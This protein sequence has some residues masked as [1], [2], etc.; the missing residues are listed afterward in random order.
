V[1]DIIVDIAKKNNVHTIGNDLYKDGN[2]FS[3]GGGKTKYVNYAFGSKLHLALQQL[4][5]NNW[6]LDGKI[7]LNQK[8][9]SPYTV[10]NI[11]ELRQSLGMEKFSEITAFHSYYEW[12]NFHSI[13]LQ[14]NLNKEK[15][16]W[17]RV[18]IREILLEKYPTIQPW[19]WVDRNLLLTEITA[20]SRIR[21]DMQLINR[22]EPDNIPAF[23]THSVYGKVMNFLDIR[24]SPLII[25]SDGAHAHGK[26]AAKTASSFAICCLDIRSSENL[27][28]A[29]WIHR[30][31]IPILARTCQLPHQIGSTQADIAHGEG[32]A[33]LMQ[34]MCFEAN[35]PRI[36][37]SDSKAIREQF[38]NIR[39]DNTNE[40]DRN[41]VRKAAGG[42]SKYLVSIV[43][44][45]INT[46]MNCKPDT[47]NSD[48]SGTSQMRAK[49]QQRTDHFL[50]IAKSWITEDHELNGENSTSKG[51]DQ[52]YFDDHR[53]R[54]IL[55]VDSHQLDKFGRRIK[56]SPRY[57]SLVPNIALLSANHHADVGAEIGTTLAS[58]FDNTDAPKVITK[59]KTP[60]SS[61]TFSLMCE[62]ETVDRHI[63]EDINRRFQT[64]RIKRLKTKQTQGFLWRIFP[65]VTI[66]WATLNLHKGFF[67][68]LLGMSNSHSRCIYKSTTYRAGALQQHL[69]TVDDA[70]TRKSIAESSIKDQNRYIL[71]CAWCTTSNSGVHKGNRRHVIL[72]CSNLKISKFRRRMMNLIGQHISTFFE[73]LEKIT[74][75]YAT[76]SFIKEIEKVFLK[77]QNDQM[78]CLKKLSTARNILYIDIQSCLI[79][80]QKESITAARESNAIEFFLNLF[81]VQPER[82]AIEPTDEE[83]GVLDAI[84]MGLMPSTVAKLIQKHIKICSMRLNLDERSSWRIQMEHSW[85]TIENLNMGRVIGIHRIMS[86]VGSDLEQEFIS[87]FHLQDLEKETRKRKM[88]RKHATAAGKA[89]AQGINAKRQKKLTK[90]Q[91]S[92][93]T[94]CNGITCGIEKIRWCS[95]SKLQPNMIRVNRKQCLRC[96]LFT[97]AM[98]TTVNMLIDLQSTSESQQSKLIQ[99]LR[100]MGNKK[101]IN[102]SSLMNMLQG[103]IPKNKQFERAQYISKYRPTEKWKK[104]CKLLIELASR[105]K[106][107]INKG[108]CAKQ[109]LQT[110]ITDMEQTLHVKNNELKTDALFLRKCMEQFQAEIQSPKT[111]SK[112][113]SP[114]SKLKKKAA[115]GKH[116][117]Q[118]CTHQPIE[119][120][121]MV[122]SNDSVIIIDNS[123]NSTN[124]EE[125]TTSS[126]HHQTQEEREELLRAKLNMMN[127]R[128]YT[129]GKV[130]LMAIEVLRWRHK[131]QGIFVACPEAAQIIEK[132]NPNEGWAR[133]ARIFYSINVCN[134]KPNGL[135]LIPIFSGDSNAG[136]WK[137]VAVEK[138]G[139]QRRAVLIDSLGTGQLEDPVIR[140]ITQAFSPNRGSISWIAPCSRQQTGVECGARTICALSVLAQA[141]C[142]G[143]TLQEGTQRATLMDATGYD[144]MEIRRTAARLVGEYRSNMISRAI[145]L[146]R[147]R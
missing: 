10:A 27:A 72:H 119:E 133:F 86:G 82:M 64:E 67:R 53:T 139:G 28:S 143:K 71:K 52:H 80:L 92:V 114:K 70:E 44:E 81:H 93:N 74:S 112:S 105:D 73:E 19:E 50:Q 141:F 111:K 102:F 37:I 16:Y 77:L 60:S 88:K 40:I 84:W 115:D 15:Q 30:P 147:W 8:L 146:R 22:P 34:E 31:M 100:K 57:T 14:N 121:K 99:L 125:E 68:S 107:P 97:T 122:G 96:S 87:K 109:Y 132:W 24:G 144:Q 7:D 116:K 33:F 91:D 18:D 47:T 85:K 66:K 95:Q 110:W 138:S 135:Y 63:S 98:K 36:I 136:H 113:D 38:L 117:C 35:F 94:R 101:K 124:E 126:V 90:D 134:R 83:L 61:L 6:T 51:W 127:R 89:E 3:I 46:K 4:Q 131:E 123:P 79:K 55:K 21:W 69:Q 2:G 49:F 29:E 20:I 1:N 43:R 23:N 9:I 75:T 13:V 137:V 25:A 5:R 39:N 103:C 59:F 108:N 120:G 104:I 65:Y 78:G 17:K 48:R 42:I 45:H 128:L 12:H 11:L 106:I 41:F 32:M 56:S 76:I 62:G 140:L 118:E 130:L 129:A 58:L 54:P 145:R 26:E 142:E